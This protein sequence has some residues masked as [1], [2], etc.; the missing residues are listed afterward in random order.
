M[1]GFTYFMPEEAGYRELRMLFDYL[2]SEGIVN[3]ANLFVLDADDLLENPEE[4]IRRYC[5]VVDIEYKK[6]MLSWGDNDGCEKFEKW[7]GFHEDAIGSSGLKRREKKERKGL[8]EEY[9]GWVQ[10]WG[11]EAAEVIKATCL[12]CWEDYEYLKG[13]KEN[14]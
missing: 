4:A 6:E 10:K 2:R 1:T 13:F 3:D 5:D 9:I 14:F 7:K 11:K 8:E 12:E